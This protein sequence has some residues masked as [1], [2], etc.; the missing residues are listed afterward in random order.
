MNK[1]AK[2][3]L[4]PDG[5]SIHTIE[6]SREVTKAEYRRLIDELL[7]NNAG[8]KATMYK[9]RSTG[10][11][12]CTRFS[13]CGL[14][15]RLESTNDYHFVRLVVNP[16]IMTTAQ[17]E[18]LGIFQNAREN[19]DLLEQTFTSVLKN[20]LFEHKMTRY[21]LSRVDLCTNIRCTDKT[22]FRE[23]VRALRKT[24]TPK[25]YQRRYFQHKDKKKANR[26]NKHFIRLSCG[27]QELIIYDKGY[28]IRENKLETKLEGLA[29]RVLRIEVHLGRDKLRRI[30]KETGEE[31]PVELLWGVMQQSRERILKLT[32]KCYPDLPYL[33]YE[34]GKEMIINSSFHVE[35]KTRMLRLLK[36]MRRRQTVDA[37]LQ[38]MEQE[39]MKTDDL[40]KRFAKLGL[41]PVPLRKDFRVKR[42]PSLIHI[43][44]AVGESLVEIQLGD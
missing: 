40:L 38:M 13:D 18:Y 44:K 14:R 16:R 41:N 22:V 17:N 43:L 30:E 26:Y 6:L 34:D 8:K 7:R 12:I 37:A 15:I 24:P 31:N 35:T 21:Y 3:T 2:F 11:Y 4:E 5:S 36:L 33:H 27:Q 19:V 9:D 32:E 20:T 23:L 25:K 42:M 1:K 29:E 10:S 39:H 28:Q